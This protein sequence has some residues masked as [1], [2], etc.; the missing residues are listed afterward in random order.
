MNSASSRRHRSSAKQRAP[1]RRRGAQKEEK[2]TKAD[3][4]ANR[5]FAF[6]ID[7]DT[8]QIVKFEAV[9]GSGG[10][11][12]LS[13]EEKVALLRKGNERRIEEVV[14][15]AFEAGIGCALDEEPNEARTEEADETDED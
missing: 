5:L 11:R 15:R 8:A 2:M 12:E 13:Q 4:S 7:A 6:T 9:D 3:P 14:E 10:H 1:D